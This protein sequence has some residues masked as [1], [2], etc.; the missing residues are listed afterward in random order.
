MASVPG[1]EGMF[2][3]IAELAYRAG[4][5][6]VDLSVFDV[7]LKRARA[8]YGKRDDLGY[9][10]PWLG[11]RVPALRALRGARLSPPGPSAPHALDDVDPELVGLDMLPR[12]PESMTVINDRTTN[13][14]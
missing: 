14:S 13:W 3:A 1:K 5:K 10:P 11:Q 2:R 4:A 12:L 8:L 6:F 7:H 9:V